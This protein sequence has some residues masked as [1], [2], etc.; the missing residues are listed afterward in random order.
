ME[1]IQHVNDFL[2]QANTFYL[3]TVD[4]NQPKCRPV[5]FH[6]LCGEQLYF[7]VGDFKEVYKQMQKNPNVEFCATVGTD[8]LRYYGKAVFEK[9]YHIA[10]KVLAA[11]PAMQKIYNE[12]TGYKLAIFHLENATAEFRNMLGI[13]KSYTFGAL[14]MPI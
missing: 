13:K 2:T 7:G 12:K 9:S 5:A 1:A 10:E 6:M 14:P 11:A 3:T 8:F 4:G